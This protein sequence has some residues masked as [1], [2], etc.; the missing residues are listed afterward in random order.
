VEPHEHG[1]FFLPNFFVSKKFHAPLSSVV[2]RYLYKVG[3][4][5]YNED[6]E[7]ERGLTPWELAKILRSTVSKRE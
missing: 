2:K 6:K 7:E 5:C 3:L 1:I 4:V